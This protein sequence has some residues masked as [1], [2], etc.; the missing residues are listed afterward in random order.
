MV[1]YAQCVYMYRLIS[2][3][4]CQLFV[5]GGLRTSLTRTAILAGDLYSWY[6]GSQDRQVEG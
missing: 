2:P 1:I 6:R 3:V 4:Y 5:V